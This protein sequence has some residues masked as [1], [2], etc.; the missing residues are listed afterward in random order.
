[1]NPIFREA[2]YIPGRK[3]SLESIK[4]IIGDENINEWE[5]KRERILKRLECVL[6][7]IPER[8]PVK[9]DIYNEKV[10]SDHIRYRLRINTYNDDIITAYLLVPL[11]NL[12]NEPVKAI[13]ALHQTCSQGKDEPA[14]ITGICDYF[15]GLDLVKRGY[16]VLVPDV[17]GAGERV[18]DGDKPYATKTFYKRYP[19]WSYMGKMLYD[20]MQCIDFLYT[21]QQIDKMGIGVIGHSK[22]GYNALFLAAFDTRVKAVVSSCGYQ[23]VTGEKDKYR[24]VRRGYEHF[25]P[26]EECVKKHGFYPFEFHEVLA[27]IAPRACFSW[28][29]KCDCCFPNY[30]GVEKLIKM[31]TPVYDLYD[32]GHLLIGFLGEEG[33]DFPTYAREKAYLF[34]KEN[35]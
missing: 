18:D 8:V 15:Y 14:G 19:T 25:K 28:Y 1:M 29:T 11:N 9:A 23:P 17:K 30:V 33:H 22:G 3:G 24:W 31:A 6:G 13:I 32:K 27:C 35:L 10:L 2:I 5:K 16:I 4:P 20:H 7:G 26:I 34:L 21:Q 12:Y